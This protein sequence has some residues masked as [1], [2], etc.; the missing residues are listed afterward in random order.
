MKQC[1][2]YVV[3]ASQCNNKPNNLF[4]TNIYVKGG[5]RIA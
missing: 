4:A 1:Y 5:K 3:T 2:Y